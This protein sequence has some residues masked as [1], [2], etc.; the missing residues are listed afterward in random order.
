MFLSAPGESEM[1]GRFSKF[2]KSFGKFPVNFDKI[3]H[4]L[5]FAKDFLGKPCAY[6][7]N[8]F[9]ADTLVFQKQ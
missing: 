4:Q 5:N 8:V 2:R 9:S 7:L 3:R 6:F 1:G